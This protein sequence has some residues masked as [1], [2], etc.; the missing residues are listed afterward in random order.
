MGAEVYIA[1]SGKFSDRGL[2]AFVDG[3]TAE[4]RAAAVMLYQDM[5]IRQQEAGNEPTA[6]VWIGGKLFEPTIEELEA[7]DERVRVIRESEKNLPD[8]IAEIAL[9]VSPEELST[10]VQECPDE[11]ELEDEPVDDELAP[12]DMG[13]DFDLDFDF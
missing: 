1:H 3:D 6:A 9:T 5:R 7:H 13:G 10:I 12:P 11:S 2:W 4:V 8:E